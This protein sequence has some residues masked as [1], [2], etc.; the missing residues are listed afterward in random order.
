LSGTNTL[1]MFDT[2]SLAIGGACLEPSGGLI[3]PAYT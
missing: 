3:P 2:S 1:L